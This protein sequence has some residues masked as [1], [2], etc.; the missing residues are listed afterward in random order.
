MNRARYAIYYAPAPGTPLWSFGSSVLGYDAATG[1]AKPP[2]APPGVGPEDWARI[3]A[4]PRRYGFHATLKAPFRL[5]EGAREDDLVEAGRT[6]A[7]KRRSFALPD[8]GIAALDSFVALTPTAHSEPLHALAAASVEAFEPFRAPL[9]EAELAHRLE[10]RLNPRQREA[11]ARWGYPYVFEDFRFHM[12][13]TGPLQAETIP[14]VMS[15]LAGLY[16][17]HVGGVPTTV[18]AVTLYVEEA[19]GEDFRIVDRFVFAAS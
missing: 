19:P 14:L 7:R 11:L 17:D 9:A 13:L 16:A 15:G 18:D 1:A 12:T 4:Q 6:F 2:L 10:A 8:L 3:T 5:A